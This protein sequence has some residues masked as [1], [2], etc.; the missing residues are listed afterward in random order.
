MTTKDQKSKVVITH[1]VDPRII[2]TLE[3]SFHVITNQT[4]HT[5]DRSEILA[6]C[7]DAVGLMV[8]M[9]DS[10]D[11]DFLCQCPRLKTIAGALRGYDNFDID[12]CRSHGV[13]FTI[14]PDLL[15]Q[16]TAEL[17]LALVL[18]LGRRL[19]EGDDY[20]RSGEFHGWRPQ[21]Y[22]FGVMKR[23]IGVVGM[24]RL[25]RAFTRVVSGLDCTVKY[26]DQQQLNPD[27]H[28]ELGVEYLNF[29]SL[30]K[31]SDY[32]VMMLPLTESTHH[33]INKDSL[34]LL[35][36]GSFLVNVGRG[37]TVDEI[38]VAD[39]LDS[40]LLAGYAA[41]VFE[42]EDWVREDRP[43]AINSRL[44]E[45][46]SNTFFTP[47]VGS[48]VSDIRYEIELEAAQSLLSSAPNSIN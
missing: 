48:A 1:R 41:D 2:R 25:G 12:A 42:M 8:F 36:R 29:E 31:W 26:Y 3:T 9:P 5:L 30:L 24:G 38:A 15:A 16:P 45:S 35:K 6:R 34:S 32:L 21:L 10:I 17:A 43:N 7:S 22:S 28:Q 13:N 47:H 44:I 37:S 11:E 39:S 19:L 27:L 14:V 20:M 4:S 18:A 46:K 33:L 40:G 23:R